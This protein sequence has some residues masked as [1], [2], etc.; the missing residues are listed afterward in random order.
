MNSTV[1]STKDFAPL[2]HRIITAIKGKLPTLN[3]F[4]ALNIQFKHLPMCKEDVLNSAHVRIICEMLCVTGGIVCVL[5][6]LSTYQEFCFVSVEVT[7]SFGYQCRDR[8]ELNRMWESCKISISKCC[9]NLRK[10]SEKQ[11]R[12]N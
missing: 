12:Q 2:N 10:N 4:S 11:T 6:N 3:L 5:P 9:Q 8:E 7:R 1:H